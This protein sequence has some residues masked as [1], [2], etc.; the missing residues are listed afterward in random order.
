VVGQESSDAFVEGGVTV[1]TL[2]FNVALREALERA[3]RR[4]SL[5]KIENDDNLHYWRSEFPDAPTSD[6]LHKH[7]SLTST[8]S[9]RSGCPLKQSRS[10]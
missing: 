1:S 3:D 5:K 9:S 6:A 4:P 2:E 7:A 10:S 8:T